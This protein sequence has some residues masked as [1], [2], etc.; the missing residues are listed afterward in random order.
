MKITLYIACLFCAVQIAFAAPLPD[1]GDSS[2]VIL[3]NT[4]SKKI[5]QDALSYLSHSA[6]WGGDLAI[7]QY[8]SDLSSKLVLSPYG[9]WQ[10]VE[11]NDSSINAFA[12][13]GGVIGVNRGLMLATESES[14]LASVLAHELAHITQNHQAR[15]MQSSQYSWL[16]QI[17]GVAAAAVLAQKDDGNAATVALGAGQAIPLEAKLARSR[18]YEREADRVGMQYLQ[19]AGFNP[20]AMPHFFATLQQKSRFEGNNAPDFLRTH[21]VTRNRIADSENRLQDIPY[22]QYPDSATY[23]LLKEKLRVQV[24]DAQALAWYQLALAD[25]RYQQRAVHEYGLSLAALRAG[26]ISLAEQALSSALQIIPNHPLLQ[27]QKIAILAAKKDYVA[28]LASA[29]I[30]ILN[31]PFQPFL[32]QQSILIALE[33]NDSPM[34]I[35]FAQQA[36]Q[37]FSD[38]PVFIELL[39]RSYAADQRFLDEKRTLA[40][41]YSSLGQEQAALDQIRIAQ[42]LPDLNKI[43]VMQLQSDEQALRQILKEKNN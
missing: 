20:A 32:Y 8:L 21:P 34:A 7:N 11:L 13:P 41:Y 9:R 22:K 39:A 31:N 25:K 18:D 15:E 12:I 35:Q 29:K 28:A 19:D 42:R 33:G 26:D 43:E 14:E 16:W 37:K 5:A 6:E 38:H 23:L 4:Q 24:L 10:A 3:T 36:V 30:A 27:G 17:V 2:L 1:L 40:Q